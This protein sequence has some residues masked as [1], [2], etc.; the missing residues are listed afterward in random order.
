MTSEAMVRH[1]VGVEGANVLLDIVQGSWQ[2]YLDEHQLRFHRSTRAMVVWDHMV[3]RS[4]SK[5]SGADG[6]VRIERYERPIYVMRNLFML[7][8]KMHDRESLTRNYPTKAQQGV[9]ASGLFPGQAV[10]NVAFGYRLD[11]AE[12]GIEQCCI[13]SPA[14]TWVIDLDDLASGNLAPSKPMLEMPDYDLHWDNVAPIR[15]TEAE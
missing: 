2:D 10:P 13:T 6:V 5:L 8:P 9:V 1:V 3:K 4:D 7:R 11:A 14:D 12:A 15:F